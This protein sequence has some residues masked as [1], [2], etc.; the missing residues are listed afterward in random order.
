VAKNL[1]VEVAW[2]PVRNR[3]SQQAY[4]Q[5]VHCC[6]L[7][8]VP[9]NAAVEVVWL[10][11]RSSVWA[12]VVVIVHRTFPHLSIEKVKQ[13][14]SDRVVQMDTVD[15]RHCFRVLV[16][17]D[18]SWDHPLMDRED[19]EAYTEVAVDYSMFSHTCHLKHQIEFGPIDNASGAGLRLVARQHQ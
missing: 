17:V 3:S 6:T 4:S 13:S 10:V 2:A 5:L 19:I 8:M 12:K 18:S 9:D 1:S 16:I 11:E 14:R 7:D 15:D